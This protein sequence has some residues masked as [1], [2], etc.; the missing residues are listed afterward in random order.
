MGW[1]PTYLLEEQVCELEGGTSTKQGSFRRNAAPVSSNQ[2]PKQSRKVNFVHDPMRRTSDLYSKEKSD[3]DET[4]TCAHHTDPFVD[5]T[6]IMT[7]I[8]GALPPARQR[9]GTIEFI[10]LCGFN[11]LAHLTSSSIRLYW[12][13]VLNAP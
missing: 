7:N 3:Q 12:M 1:K 6:N 10:G 9:T 4:E 13:L 8:R 5:M 2:V 11:D